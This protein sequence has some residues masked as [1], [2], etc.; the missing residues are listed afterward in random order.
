[1]CA[2]ISC[3]F[4]AGW[5]NKITAHTPA[6]SQILRNPK[7]SQISKNFWRAAPPKTYRNS[8]ALPLRRRAAAR[9]VQFRSLRNPPSLGEE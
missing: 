8:C 3:P 5:L 1:M 2:V 9:E 6:T 4:W 7:N